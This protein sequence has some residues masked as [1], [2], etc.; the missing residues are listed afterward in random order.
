[1]GG[2]ARCLRGHRAGQAKSED[3]KGSMLCDLRGHRSL[4]FYKQSDFRQGGEASLG[5]A[6][7]RMALQG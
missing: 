6:S 7:W 2:P 4:C 5:L 3:D 1:M